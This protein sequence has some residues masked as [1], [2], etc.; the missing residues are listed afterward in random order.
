M[1]MPFAS[2]AMQKEE[3]LLPHT[4][5]PIKTVDIY[6]WCIYKT[7]LPNLSVA[8]TVSL[9]DIRGCHDS[10]CHIRQ[11]EGIIRADATQN[12]R[13]RFSAHQRAHLFC[14]IIQINCV[15]WGGWNSLHLGCL[16]WWHAAQ[17]CGL[18]K[19]LWKLSNQSSFKL[20]LLISD[21]LI[22]ISYTWMILPNL[23][24]SWLQFYKQEFPGC[25][26]PYQ[27]RRCLAFH[28]SP[29]WSWICQCKPGAWREALLGNWK[30]NPWGY[31]RLYPGQRGTI[32][33]SLLQMTAHPC[34]T[35]RP[36]KH[37]AVG[38][39]GSGGGTH[40]LKL[41]PKMRL[42]SCRETPC[43]LGAEIVTSHP[44]CQRVR[45]SSLSTTFSSS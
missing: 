9:D 4:P 29:G 34:K 21:I 24:L 42:P 36:L 22:A 17:K 25:V 8:A 16:P 39:R 28:L 13:R 15:G 5:S 20:L 26:S 1:L 18:G 38:N 12:W 44:L 14:G 35:H 30:F 45:K 23:H 11:R 3:S 40:P 2:L 32:S 27:G 43:F 19:T 31:G 41:W 10:L 37:K 6:T 33:W 7:T